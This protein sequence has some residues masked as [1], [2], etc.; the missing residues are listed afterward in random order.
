MVKHKSKPV[1]ELYYYC[2]QR[3]PVWY[4]VSI[5]RNGDITC[6]LKARTCVMWKV[7]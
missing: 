2:G 4:W 1:G 7:K 3:N 5:F 6:G